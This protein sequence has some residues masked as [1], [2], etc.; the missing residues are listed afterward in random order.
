MTLQTAGLET[1][2]DVRCFVIPAN[3]LDSWDT[4]AAQVIALTQTELEKISRPVYLCGESFGGCVALKVLA[5]APQLFDRIILINSASSFHRV[6]LLNLGSF[7]LPWTP[8]FFYDLSSVLAL[9]FLAEVFRLPLNARKALLQATQDAPKPTAEQRLEL[10][11][12][13]RI[14]AAK[15]RQ[16]TQPVLLIGSRDDRL[17]PSV[18]EVH[19]LAEVFPNSQTITLPHSGHACLVETDINLLTLLRTANFLPTLD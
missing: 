13:F 9:P 17:L 10:L 19:R 18:E 4:L 5:Q 12:E 7:L 2:F 6:P 3:A 1:T 8:Q 16:V 11:R 15:L 14:S